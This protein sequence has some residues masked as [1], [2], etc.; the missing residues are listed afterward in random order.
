M[1]KNIVISTTSINTGD[2]SKPLTT[3]IFT[4]I[5]DHKNSSRTL[6]GHVFSDL[7]L[8]LKSHFYYNSFP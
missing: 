1:V 2:N 3:Q 5:V 7:E 6:V 8:D 4:Y